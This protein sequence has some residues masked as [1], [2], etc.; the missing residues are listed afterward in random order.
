MSWFD[1]HQYNEHDNEAKRLRTT[2]LQEIEESPQRVERALLVGIH[3]RG[4]DESDALEMLDELRELLATLSIE[5]VSRVAV[6][7]GRPHP[8]LLI[9]TGKAD[10]IVERARRIEADVI[11]FD[12]PLSPAQ[13]RN[14]EKLAGITV[15]DREEI[16]LDIFAERA[17]TKEAELQISLARAQYE[18]PR[19]K[20]RWTHLSRQR[21]MAGGMGL[22]GEGEQQIEVDARLVQRRISRLESELDEVRKKRATQRKK[23]LKRPVPTAAIVGYTNAG[24]SSLLNAITGSSVNAEDKLFATLDPTTR[25]VVL[26]NQQEMLLSDTVGFIRK[27]PHSLVEAFKATL[28]EAVVADF[29]IEVLDV[30]SPALE[31]H[32][33]TTWEVLK[34][35]GADDKRVVTVLNKI[36]RAERNFVL[37]RV[38][39][40]FDNPVFTS[41]LTGEGIDELCERLAGELEDELA[42]VDL[43]VPQD[44]YDIVAKLH[45]AA[46]IDDEH[47]D[48]E[49]IR[50][51]ARVPVHMLAELD[52][53]RR[54]KKGA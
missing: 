40:R 18:L 15:I 21:G 43:V 38:R 30:T 7:L 36:D 34:E 19:L 1:I 11:V 23:R 47:Y 53:F 41:A 26:P 13:Q 45:R 24:K 37:G 46:T 14:W 22:R 44:R 16:I 20:R 28:E 35:L 17:Q 6:P 52:P 54:D 27:L 48:D 33:Q 3:D 4:T 12:D 2:K 39:R 5:T 9:G 31:E 42:A 50:I 51:Q 29:I 10:E 49:G 8:R 25:R 32:H